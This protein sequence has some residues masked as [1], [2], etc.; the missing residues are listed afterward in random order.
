MALLLRRCAA[1]VLGR[2]QNHSARLVAT[3]SI[4]DRPPTP[5]MLAVPTRFSGSEPPGSAPSATNV[6]VLLPWTALPCSPAKASL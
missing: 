5:S 4:S 1:Y 6:Q 3:I 2:S